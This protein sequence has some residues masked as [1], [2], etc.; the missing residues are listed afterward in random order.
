MDSQQHCT[1]LKKLPA[2]LLCL[3]PGRRW[4]T[5][6]KFTPWTCHLYFFWQWASMGTGRKIVSNSKLF[7]FSNNA[8][9]DSWAPIGPHGPWSNCGQI[10]TYITHMKWTGMASAIPSKDVLWLWGCGHLLGLWLARSYSPH[11]E[12]EFVPCRELSCRFPL[13]G[14]RN[15]RE[16]TFRDTE[17]RAY[18]AF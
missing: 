14:I 5:A 8:N 16:N 2:P 12:T 17:I 10:D 1:L 6:G 7:Q 4:K 13:Y 3:G 15:C 11:D 9:N 18:Q